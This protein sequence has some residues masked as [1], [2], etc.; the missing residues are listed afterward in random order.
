MMMSQLEYLS[1]IGEHTNPTFNTLK[2]LAQAPFRDTLPYQPH[3][4]VNNILL[5]LLSAWYTALG[6]FW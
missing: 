1:Y 6:N 4:Q 5:A 2:V 3:E